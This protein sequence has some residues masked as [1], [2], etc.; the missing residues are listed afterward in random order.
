MVTG[1]SGWGMG[2]MGEGQEWPITAALL[3]R[4]SRGIRLGR[5]RLAIVWLTTLTEETEKG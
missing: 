2:M 3:D 5:E 1:G 4:R